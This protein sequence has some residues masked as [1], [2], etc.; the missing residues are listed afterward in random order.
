MAT[1]FR[2]IGFWAKIGLV[3]LLVL[4]TVY[5]LLPSMAARP[6]PLDVLT[7]TAGDLRKLLSSGYSS[8]DLVRLYVG[9]IAKYNGQLRANQRSCAPR[10]TAR[11]GESVGLG[12]EGRGPQVPTP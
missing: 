10:E 12:K 8:V 5:R 9:Q 7:A 3:G 11:A 4:F 2:N 6:N 1:G